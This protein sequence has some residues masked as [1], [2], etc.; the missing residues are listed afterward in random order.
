[1][2]GMSRI[3]M[4]RGREVMARKA[5]TDVVWLKLSDPVYQLPE[6]VAD[7]AA[8]LA[9]MCGVSQSTVIA[10]ASRQKKGQREYS[11]YIMVEVG[12]EDE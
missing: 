1:M 4:V 7:S 5:R 9:K 8:E 3:H 6:L 10:N 12:E 2:Y 11:R